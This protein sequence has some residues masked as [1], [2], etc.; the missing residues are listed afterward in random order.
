MYKILLIL[1][2]N[3]MK[4]KLYL[5]ITFI[6]IG[7]LTFSFFNVLHVNKID[8]NRPNNIELYDNNNELFYSYNN[9]YQ[10]EYVELKDVSSCF[11]KTLINTEDKN[12]YNH[13]GFDYLRIIKSLFEN[14]KSN[15][16]NQFILK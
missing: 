5:F 3:I 15:S 4:K 16:L 8:I 12:F 1:H 2:N 11:I 7:L 10:G 13:H 6:I 14:I 9:D